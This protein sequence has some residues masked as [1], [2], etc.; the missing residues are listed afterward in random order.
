MLAASGLGSLEEQRGTVDAGSRLPWIVLLVD[1]WEGLQAAY[2]QVDHGR[3]LDL[4]GRLVREGAAAGFRVVLTGDRGV[5]TSRVGSAFSRRLILRLADPTD[6]GLAGI[7][8][9]RVP[10]AMPPGRVLVGADGIEAQLALLDG[11]SQVT[12]LERIAAAARGRSVDLPPDRRPMRV[13]PLPSRVELADI[14]AEAKAVAT[15]PGWAL[16]GLGGDDLVPLG[17]DLLD[18]GP[19]AVVAGPPGSGRTTALATI[20]RWLR[21]QGR[22]IAIVAHRRSPLRALGDEPGVVTCVGT[23]GA[24]A[25]DEALRTHPDLTVLADDAETLHDTP[26]ERVLLAVLRPDA[27]G[28]ASMVLAGSAADLAGCFRGVTVE[29]RRGRTGLL[30]GPLSPIDG[31]LLGVR[32]TSTSYLADGPAGRGVLVVRGRTTPVQV[33]HSPL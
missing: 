20:G 23:D 11:E 2:D 1:G 28:T 10:L 9:R 22:P 21:H 33:A 18:H 4:L 24:D 16:V 6:Y 15:G 31:D 29:A 26:I 30:L 19:A 25:L 32:L 13:E 27:P 14:E 7:P 5:L 17:V 3:P 12:A 8:P